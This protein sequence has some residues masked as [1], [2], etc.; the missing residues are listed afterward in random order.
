MSIWVAAV[1][2]V[3]A[4]GGEAAQE[5]APIPALADEEPADGTFQ[6]P[7]SAYLARPAVITFGKKMG[8]TSTVTWQ[9]KP[10]QVYGETPTV[11]EAISRYALSSARRH[12]EDASWPDKKTK[13]PKYEVRIKKVTVEAAKGPSY[14]VIVEVERV[15]K[16]RR[17]GNATGRGFAMPDRTNQRIGAS[18]V[19][20]L[21]GMAARHK[22][23]QP[24]LD[25]DAK[26]IEV[27]TL[28][29]L[30]N[31]LLQTAAIWAGEQR[32]EDMQKQYRN[33][34]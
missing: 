18:M 6:G 17:R 28:R 23:S 11:R 13:K 22:V 2:W 15:E 32:V 12:F 7:T 33:G 14:N 26:V 1:L 20:G 31:A 10:G 24:S 3:A 19:P 34:Q 30:D 29:A 27:A 16:G 4:A 25:K 8:P 5:P 21:F 9:G